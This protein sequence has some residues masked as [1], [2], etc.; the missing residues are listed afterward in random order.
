MEATEMLV[1]TPARTDQT[2]KPKQTGTAD[3]RKSQQRLNG[4]NAIR[5][6]YDQGNQQKNM[7]VLGTISLASHVEIRG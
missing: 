2:Q 7:R 1:S 3:G 4:R 6:L 5:Q